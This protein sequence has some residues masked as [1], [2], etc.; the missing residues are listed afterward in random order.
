MPLVDEPRPISTH[1]R[2]REKKIHYR[3]SIK[4]AR[5]FLSRFRTFRRASGQPIESGRRSR[6]ISQTLTANRRLRGP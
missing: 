2:D 4:T 5:M 3:Q 6:A 1:S